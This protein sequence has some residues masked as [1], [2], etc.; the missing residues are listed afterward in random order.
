ML[1][2]LLRGRACPACGAG[3]GSEGAAGAE[4]FEGHGGGASIEAR[5]TGA[6]WG[7]TS[8]VT[9]ERSGLAYA[10]GFAGVLFL[11]GR[12]LLPLVF[13]LTEGAHGLAAALLLLLSLPA[14]LALVLGFA[15]AF[16]LDR[17]PRKSGALPALFGYAVG[18]LGSMDAFYWYAV[19]AKV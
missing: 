18:M 3:R 11:F 19:W 1:E 14:P 2:L 10:A 12:A 16:T 7:A 4:W 9:P 5:I 15:A 17:S 8:A 6:L 13:S